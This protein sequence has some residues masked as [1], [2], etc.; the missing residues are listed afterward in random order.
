MKWQ[1]SETRRVSQLHIASTSI[2]SSDQTEMYNLFLY[3]FPLTL[4][5]SI[6]LSVLEHVWCLSS[7]MV[8]WHTKSTHTAYN[9][10]YI[11]VSLSPSFEI[12]HGYMRNK[13]YSSLIFSFFRKCV[14]T[15][16]SSY[17]NA[18]I[19]APWLP[20]VITMSLGYYN[21]EKNKKQ[22]TKLK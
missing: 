22:S 18:T 7:Q 10:T 2:N 4:H 6:C 13:L 12:V 14:G 8:E 20:F 3:P 11:S 21:N 17:S 19:L 16:I 5:L 1:T 9:G 15:Y